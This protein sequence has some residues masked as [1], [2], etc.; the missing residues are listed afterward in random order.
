MKILPHTY[1][2]VWILRTGYIEIRH[3]TGYSRESAI[4][5]VL[6]EVRKKAEEYAN[7]HFMVYRSNLL[8]KRL[9]PQVFR[10]KAGGPIM[11]NFLAQ[12]TRKPEPQHLVTDYKVELIKEPVK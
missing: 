4:E 5:K 2:F 11:Y 6:K 12:E 1:T 3:A 9:L 8:R 10:D 7:T